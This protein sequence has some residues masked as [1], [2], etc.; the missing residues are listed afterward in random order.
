MPTQNLPEGT[1]TLTYTAVHELMSIS[2]CSNIP[3]YETPKCFVRK[4]TAKACV[5]AFVDYLAEMSA[6]AGA[7]VAKR[8]VNVTKDL[9]TAIASATLAELP[10]VN[11]GFSNKGNY[12][13]GAELMGIRDKLSRHISVVPVIGFNSQKYDINIMKGPL[14][15]RKSRG[16]ISNS[17]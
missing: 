16:R 2:T 9:E 5:Y 6:A 7:L 15:S 4:T 10:F 14:P 11:A 17:S 13:R 3:G 8:F 1:R 12:K